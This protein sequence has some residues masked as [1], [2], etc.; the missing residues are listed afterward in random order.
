MRGKPKHL[1]SKQD[2][3]NFAKLWPAEGKQK[4]QSLL[5]GK[6]SW[7]NTGKI[8]DDGI[9]DETH[10]VSILKDDEDNITEK[11]Q[12]E[13]KENPQAK[14]FRLGFTAEEVEKLI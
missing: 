1:N 10:K 4:F 13:W 11:Y 2:Y 14:I 5:D 8:D 6:I 12:L 7:V 3:I 9:T